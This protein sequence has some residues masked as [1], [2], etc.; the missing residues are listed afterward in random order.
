MPDVFTY[1]HISYLLSL[2]FSVSYGLINIPKEC[3]FINLAKYS[4]KKGK[5]F[6]MPSN[7]N[8]DKVSHVL[9]RKLLSAAK[10]VCGH[11]GFP[12]SWIWRKQNIKLS[13][14]L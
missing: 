9:I 14:D 7:L 13:P 3:C 2:E 11:G 4:E 10:C 6:I 8:Y 12:S 5:Y 1:E